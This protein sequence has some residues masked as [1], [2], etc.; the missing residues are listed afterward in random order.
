MHRWLT[1][2]SLCCGI[3]LCCLPCAKV[4]Y[5]S[6][7]LSMQ[8]HSGC[9]CSG[10]RGAVLCAVIQK[11]KRMLSYTA[12]AEESNLLVFCFPSK[13]SQWK[14]T[15][16]QTSL[17]PI[18][19]AGASGQSS[20]HA[21]RRRRLTKDH[22]LLTIGILTMKLCSSQQLHTT[23]SWLLGTECWSMEVLNC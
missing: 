23:R 17:I 5:L 19:T 22:W 6:W 14:K 16:V 10:M 18:G 7:I 12:E 8:G 1:T 20:E 13:V 9:E 15:L 2:S 3:Q 4:G 21:R 11:P